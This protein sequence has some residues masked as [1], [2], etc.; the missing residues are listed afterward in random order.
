[1]TLLLEDRGLLDAFRRGDR[2]AYERVYR[3]FVKDVFALIRYG[4]VAGAARVPGVSDPALQLDLTQD[5]FVKAFAEKARL[6]YDGLRPYRPFVLRIAK[7]LLIDR[8]RRSGRELV[9][10]EATLEQES[11]PIEENI[12]ERLHF[13]QLRQA[14]RLFLTGES[15]ELRELVRLRFEEE[16]SQY[17]VADLMKISRRRVRTLEERAQRGLAEALRKQGLTWD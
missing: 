9:V 6:A 4:F 17:E 10:D 16:R 15:E 14:T 7:N 1:L 13:E 12:E 11:E 5:V 3:A 2:R 8:A